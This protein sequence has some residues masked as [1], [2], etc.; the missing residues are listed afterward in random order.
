MEW[1][2][3]TILTNFFNLDT[4]ESPEEFLKTKADQWEVDLN[5]E[6]FA[7]LMDDHDSLAYVRKKF[8]YPK[9]HTLPFGLYCSL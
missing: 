9:M 2:T 4:D 8:C 5:S 7:I 6:Q 1:L 3:D